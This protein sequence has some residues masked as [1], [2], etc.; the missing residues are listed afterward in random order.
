MS[1]IQDAM[2]LL[3]PALRQ[4]A[5]AT[6]LLQPG[7]SLHLRELARLT[8]SHA[9]T[10]GR[11]LGKL[12]DAGL[13][14]RS[15]QGNQTR[16]SA[17]VEHPLYPELAAMF[18][19]THGVVPALRAALEPLSGRLMLAFVYGSM[20]SGTATQRSD[21]DVM[22]V[23]DVG[24]TDVVQALYPLHDQLG[25]E[26]N[27]VVW[28]PQELANKARAGDA[29]VRDVLGKPKLWIWGGQHELEQLAGHRSPAAPSA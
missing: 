23:G 28:S 9:G 15:D 7:R 27:P 1:N 6:L 3:F 22:L 8:G 11:E 12:T 21:V 10:L 4:Q 13:L 24:F 2:D 20:A 17:N 19:K 26:I 16:Y 25:R 29:F 18:R 5:L 14:V